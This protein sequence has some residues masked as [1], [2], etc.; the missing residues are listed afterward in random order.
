MKILNVMQCTNLGGMEQSS[1]RLMAGLQQRGHSCQVL[2]LN[3]IG[4]LGPLLQKNGIAAQGLLY[5]GKGGWRSAPELRKRLKEIRSDAVIMTGHNLLAMVLLGGRCKARRLLA[6]HF[7][8]AGVKTNWQWRIIYALARSRF[9]HITYPSDFIRR[10]AAAIDPKT[11]A[12]SVT[13]RNPMPVPPLPG[14]QDRHDA[15][16]RLGLPPG[17]RLV[18]NAGWLIE[19]KRFDVFLQVAGR[20]A[21]REPDVRFVIAGDGEQRSRLMALAGQLGLGDKVLWLGWQQDMT[22][23]YRAIDVLLFNSDW[24]AFGTTPVEALSYG[25]PVVA[26][27]LNGGLGEAMDGAPLGCLYDR[28]DMDG[29]AASVLAYLNGVTAQARQEAQR[30][31]RAICGF[32][33]CVA[34][35]ERL[36]AS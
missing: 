25:I 35:V 11:A 22:A 28:H 8:H 12:I 3:P 23:F 32:E 21:A 33:N 4:E 26:S 7:H 2:S 6:M 5:R 29:M 34:Q 20:I 27:V 19:R 36:L 15:R 1:L 24:D 30:H 14:E 16:R 17:A 9:E 13:V 18:G 31:V 10:E